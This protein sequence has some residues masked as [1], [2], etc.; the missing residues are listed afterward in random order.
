MTGKEKAHE[1][2]GAPVGCGGH[3]HGLGTVSERV[4]LG[5]H[6]PHDRA[7]REGERDDVD[8]RQRAVIMARLDVPAAAALARKAS[9]RTPSV[10]TIPRTPAMRSGLRPARSTSQMA[11]NVARTLITPI[12]VVPASEVMSD[13]KPAARKIWGAK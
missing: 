12:P 5:D 6:Q 4:D 9:A 13:P 1:E 2:V 3:G 10:A 11:M 8:A 7:E